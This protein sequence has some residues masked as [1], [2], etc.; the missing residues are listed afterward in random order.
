MLDNVN[1]MDNK[2]AMID[3]TQGAN[4]GLSDQYQESLLGAD[5]GASPGEIRDGMSK[6][7]A[8]R[9][10]LRVQLQGDQ[11]DDEAAL[12]ARKDTMGLATI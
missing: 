7:N 12:Q 6:A 5:G 8:L 9:G 3:L 4:V 2:Y 11:I 10:E 1:N